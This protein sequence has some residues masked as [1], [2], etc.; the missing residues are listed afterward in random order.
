MN[1][2]DLLVS[3]T[4]KTGYKYHK[5]LKEYYGGNEKH[6]I[7]WMQFN[8]I[9]RAITIKILIKDLGE[10]TEEATMFNPN[11]LDAPSTTFY[12]EIVAALP[13]WLSAHT[14]VEHYNLDWIDEPGEIAQFTIYVYSSGDDNVSKKTLIIYKV[15]STLTVREL[16]KVYTIQDVANGFAQV[17]QSG[18]GQL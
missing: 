15:D 3:L 10:P 8:N 6:Y 14:N 9:I 18:I 1:L 13:T 17:I 12:D 16:D 11:S 7:F 4:Q 2:N 5:L